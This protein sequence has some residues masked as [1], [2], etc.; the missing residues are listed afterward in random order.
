M[1][2]TTP[3]PAELILSRIADRLLSPSA[4]STVTAAVPVLAVNGSPGSPVQ[5]PSSMTRLPM[6]RSALL[7]A[8]ALLTTVWAAA[9]FCTFTL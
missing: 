1:L 9:R 2:A 3:A 5:V 4:M 7:S 8:N 6:P